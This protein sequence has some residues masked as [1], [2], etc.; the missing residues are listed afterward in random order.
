MNHIRGM[1]TVVGIIGVLMLIGCGGGET[2]NENL[3]KEMARREEAHRK[4]VGDWK[5]KLDDE[6][7]S[8][9][10]KFTQMEEDYSRR[11]KQKDTEISDL[12]TKLAQ[13]TT[14]YETSTVVCIA[15]GAAVIGA[16]FVGTLM[17][18]KGRRDAMRVCKDRNT[19]T[20]VVV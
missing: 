18:A 16:L 10:A 2:P 6:I 12:K 17:G 19:P 13:K 1:S 9:R 14:Q 11:L 8:S 5:Q 20:E 7:Q 3:Q 4:E 15:L